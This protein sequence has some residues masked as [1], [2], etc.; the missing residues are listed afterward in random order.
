[1]AGFPL[2]FN[3]V[4][5]VLASAIRQQ[6]EVKGIKIGKEE[7]RLSLSTDNTILYVENPED[8][9][10]SLLELID[11]FSKVAGYKINVQK[12]VAFLD[13]NNEATEREMKW[14]AG[15]A[16][17]VKRPTSARSRSRGP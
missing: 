16:Q 6:N 8:S 5:D 15:V 14:G 17:S 2:L 10:K 12:S 4:M 7:V 11:E 9:I 1:M 3:L 13:T